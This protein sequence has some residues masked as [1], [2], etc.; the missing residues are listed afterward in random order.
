MRIPIHG[1][2]RLTRGAKGQSI[3]RAGHQDIREQDPDV[4]APCLQD[5]QGTRGAAN[6]RDRV[7]MIDQYIGDRAANQNLV[8]DHQ[9]RCGGLNEH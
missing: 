4:G 2:C 1:Q 8:L 6:F 5:G 9:N 3:D 7:A